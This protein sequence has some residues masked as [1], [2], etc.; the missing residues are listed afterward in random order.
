VGRRLLDLL[1]VWNRSIVMFLVYVKMQLQRSAVPIVHTLVLL[2]YLFRDLSV[3]CG[4]RQ[5]QLLTLLFYMLTCFTTW[6]FSRQKYLM[7]RC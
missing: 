7:H 6:A 4:G 5:Y 3:N 2:A 1:Q